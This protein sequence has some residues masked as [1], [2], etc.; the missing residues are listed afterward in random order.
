MTRTVLVF[1]QLTREILVGAAPFLLAISSWAGVIRVPEDQP[2]V[3]A[4]LDA[5]VA[6]DTVLVAP[7]VWTDREARYVWIGGELELMI[8]CGV[9]KGGV[10]LVGEEGP[11]VTVIDAQNPDPPNVCVLLYVDPGGGS[12]V[13][14][15]SLVG[16]RQAVIAVDALRLQ[17]TNCAF[18]GNRQSIF[19]YG[20]DLAM[21]DCLVS[22]NL[23]PDYAVLARETNAVDLE[24]CRFESNAARAAGFGQVA[25]LTIHACEFIGHR[26]SLGGAVEVGECSIDIS[27]SLFLRN[28]IVGPEA[29]YG[30]GLGVGRSSGFIRFNTFAYDSSLGFT[31]GGGLG[32]SEFWGE[33]SNNTFYS[34]HSERQ[35]H[36][37]CLYLGGCTVT[38]SE[39]LITDATG[40][41]AV[42]IAANTFNPA[43]GCNLY[44]RNLGGDVFNGDPF[45]TDIWADPLYCDPQNLDFTVA[46]NSPCLPGAT[47]GCGQIGAWGE[48]C[49]GVSVEA[50]SWGR[51]KS[52][53]R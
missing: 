1:R 37:G 52:L 22:H 27:E 12:V 14:G 50:T 2:S 43:S 42:T 23:E 4:G 38:V 28:A 31:W 19:A 51:I 41:E 18:H 44:W 21:T 8:L 49:G 7:G 46:A 36:G 40:H 15:V 47:P 17:F 20:T 10:T 45:P 13:R 11:D 3:L 16:A 5:A 39:N 34:C 6:G 9:L 48:G 26:P 30:G 33:V 35:G 24:R 32:L 29:G 25:S 53:Y